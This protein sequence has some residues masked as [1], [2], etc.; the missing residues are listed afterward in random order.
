MPSDAFTS[1]G[2]NLIRANRSAS[3][4]RSEGS[5]QGC[6]LNTPIRDLNSLGNEEHLLLTTHFTCVHT[7]SHD[8]CIEINQTLKNA[9]AKYTLL[10]K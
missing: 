6:L 2:A 8:L 7:I 5:M 4:N 3:S 1:P 9:Y 10:E